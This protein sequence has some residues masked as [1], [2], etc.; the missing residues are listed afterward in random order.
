MSL[1]GQL[2]GICL[3]LGPLMVCLGLACLVGEKDASNRRVIKQITAVCLILTTIGYVGLFKPDLSGVLNRVA[4][5][6]AQVAHN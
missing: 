3:V 1:T 5:A 6:M 2:L 4:A